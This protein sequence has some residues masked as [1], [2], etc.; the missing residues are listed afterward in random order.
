MSKNRP[1][2]PGVL[3]RLHGKGSMS[4]ILNIERERLRQQ[5]EQAMRRQLGT[6]VATE[7]D[8]K[9]QTEEAR[10]IPTLQPSILTGSTSIEPQINTTL[11]IL[12]ISAT[13]QP[14]NP[15]TYLPTINTA[16]AAAPR[17]ISEGLSRR[18]R[19]VG[20]SLPDMDDL[21]IH[22]ELDLEILP[23]VP[24]EIDLFYRQRVFSGLPFSSQ[25][26]LLST[27]CRLTAGFH[28]SA[29]QITLAQLAYASGIR[30]VKTLRK[31]LNDLSERRLIRYTPIH[32]DPRGPIIALLEPEGPR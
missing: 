27:I 17:R 9:V 29:C 12:T 30:N 22:H 6:E 2:P 15:P 28:K 16:A 5:S 19:F 18:S 14:T 20:E 23:A 25:R 11:S 31:W 24:S 32:G 26:D 3:A 1:V 8:T 13:G 10:E 7:I 21:I 4:E